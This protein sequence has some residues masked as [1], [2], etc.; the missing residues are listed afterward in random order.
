MDPKYRYY[1]NLDL[2][3]GFQFRALG[4][5]LVCLAGLPATMHEHRGWEELGEQER[6]KRSKRNFYRFLN[7]WHHREDLLVS[8]P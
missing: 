8:R 4:L 7:A 5:Q 2:H 1:R 6:D 3:F